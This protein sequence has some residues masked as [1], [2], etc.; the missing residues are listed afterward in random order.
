MQETVVDFFNHIPCRFTPTPEHLLGG[1]KIKKVDGA[2]VF[3]C[4]YIYSGSI[5]V[6]GPTHDVGYSDEFFIIWGGCK[7]KTRQIEVKLQ[8]LENKQNF[9]VVPYFY[10]KEQ[11]EK[12]S[13]NFPDKPVYLP[14]KYSIG[15]HFEFNP[16]QKNCIIFP[17]AVWFVSGEFE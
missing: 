15:S 11:I 5:F 4:P 3:Y 7:E 2:N 10:T 12:I 13:S 9:N 6:G 8:Q 17:A 1:C 16:K 14:L